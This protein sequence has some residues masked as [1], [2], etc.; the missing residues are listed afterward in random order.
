[1]ITGSANYT[2]R[3]L[4]GYNLETNIQVRGPS[5]ALFFDSVDQWFNALWKNEG[6]AYSLAYEHHAAPSVWRNVVMRFQEFTGLS[7]F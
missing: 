7:T 4:G 1:V 6:G 3:N 2:R 5:S